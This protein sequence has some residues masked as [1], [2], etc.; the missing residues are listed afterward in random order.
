[1]FDFIYSVVRIARPQIPDN[2][3]QNCSIDF[4]VYHYC[5]LSLSVQS[6]E[7]FFKTAGFSFTFMSQWSWI[8]KFPWFIGTHFRW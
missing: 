5:V 8:A 7:E 1:M 3:M 6:I 2:K 4:L